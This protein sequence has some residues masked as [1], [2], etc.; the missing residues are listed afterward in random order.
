MGIGRWVGGW[1]GRVGVVPLLAADH[2]LGHRPHAPSKRTFLTR[3]PPSL[4]AQTAPQI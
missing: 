4:A 3:P 2:Q 1:V